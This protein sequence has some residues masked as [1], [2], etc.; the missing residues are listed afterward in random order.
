MTTILFNTDETHQDIKG[1]QNMEVVTKPN[2]WISLVYIQIVWWIGGSPVYQ[3]NGYK[4]SNQQTTKV[5]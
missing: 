4:Y 5:K 1:K 3:I 2:G